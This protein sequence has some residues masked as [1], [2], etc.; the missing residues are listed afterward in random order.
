[1][2][3]LLF[4]LLIAA[5]A[6]TLSCKA[7]T[8][9]DVA[10]TFVKA[11]S[12]GQYEEA[13]QLFA[14][15]AA[16][17]VNADV[18]K[19]GWAQI[20]TMFGSYQSY[21]LPE[22]N[23][24]ANP[25]VV[26][27]KFEREAKG[28][29]CR[30]NDKHQLLGFVLSEAPEAKDAPPV[31][32]P[33]LFKEEEVS[34]NTTGGTLKGTMM[35]P[36]N[37]HSGMPAAIIIAGSGATDRN[38]NSGNKLNSNAYRMLAETLAAQGIA[39]LRYDKRMIGASNNFGS[40]ESKLRFDDFVTDAVNIGEYLRQQKQVTKLYIIGHS[41][42]AMIGMLAANKLNA[43]AY[44]SLCGAGENIAATL[45]RQIPDERVVPI[46]DNLK[47]GIPTIDVPQE[48]QVVFRSSI[49]YYLISWMKYEPTTEIRKLKMPILIVGG[50]T[51][52]Q[53]PVADA[54]SLKKAKPDA[55]LKII[56]GMNHVLK[57]AP[58]DK[59][60]NMVTYNQPSLPLNAELSAVLIQFLKEK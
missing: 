33:S 26:S 43:A 48:F 37:Y 55:T 31:T 30:F 45:K 25:L 53:V 57:D 38:G 27:V 52:I 50:T 22:G 39:S 32:A 20:T 3:K 44:V 13:A 49:Q 2:K 60:A 28:F 9:A 58:A 35:L 47:N 34:V 51:D 6:I 1:M 16:S 23:K 19:G 36:E 24:N 21:Q 14:P 40:D 42:G 54:E 10:A 15:E 59:T 18:L 8:N 4:L 29:G 7:Q 56:T 11:I 46:L 5:T 12:S 17:A 41:E